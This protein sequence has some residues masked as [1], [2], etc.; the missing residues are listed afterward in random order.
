[1]QARESAALRETLQV[2][3]EASSA[4]L[5]A[6]KA[7]IQKLEGEIREKPPPCPVIGEDEVEARRR[8]EEKAAQEILQLKKAHFPIRKTTV[9]SVPCCCW[10]LL[11]FLLYL[12]RYR[13]C[14]ERRKSSAKRQKT[15]QLACL[16]QRRKK[17]VKITLVGS[18]RARLL[19]NRG[20]KCNPIPGSIFR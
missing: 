18:T 13:A 7:I 8:A 9:V 5:E 2:E 14:R 15:S 20:C 16:N 1:M 4:E 6:L 3:R 10:C 12:R 17:K 19:L 11:S